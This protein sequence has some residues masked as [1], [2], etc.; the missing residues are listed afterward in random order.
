VEN[1]G[2][3][4]AHA[5]RI[6]IRGSG[7]RSTFAEWTRRFPT[8]AGIAGPETLLRLRRVSPTLREAV[9]ATLVRLMREGDGDA[10]LVL[11]ELLRPGLARRVAWFEG[12]LDPDEA[13]Q[14]MVA[15]TLETARSFEPDLL[16]NGIAR[17]LL[18]QAWRRVAPKRR[19]Y[20]QR[21]NV[22]GPLTELA[23]DAARGIWDDPVP[24]A[25]P[26][27]AQAAQCG[28]LSAE[29]AELIR[30]T[31]LD[32]LR[33]HEAAPDEPY[34]RIKKRRQ[35]AEARL[36]EFAKATY[37]VGVPKRERPRRA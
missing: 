24:A 13:W 27:I 1:S 20:V 31:R 23:E 26:L 22:E 18:R 3:R 16:R 12:T 35:R 32:G 2:D 37:P 6:L 10:R 4:I 36:A 7:F 17:D 25:A 9:F 33:L 28:A 8:L 11:L 19:R 5:A 21:R 29:E 14:E 34:E 15:A 30:A